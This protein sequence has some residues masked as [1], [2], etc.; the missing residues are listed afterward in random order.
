MF[1]LSGTI[2]IY[3][4]FIESIMSD[5]E[6]DSNLEIGSLVDTA[7][8]FERTID[9]QIQLIDGIDNK[10]EH[11]TRLLGILIGAI[12]SVLAV[13]VRI[14]NGKIEPPNTPLFI[15]FVFGVLSLILAMAFS[16]ITYLSSRFKIGLHYRPANLLSQG[17]YDVVD[18]KHYKRIIGTYGYALEKNKDVIEVNS[19][20]FRRALVFLLIGVI[21]LSGSGIS[22]ISDLT[23]KAAG[24]SL[25]VTSLLSLIIGGYI[26]SGR[27]LTLDDET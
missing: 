23:A 8:R 7:D 22:Y 21:F 6:E 13:G 15:M 4:A 17:D 11:V 26:F 3:Y 27:Y 16:I 10:A 9:H 19:K 18:R 1:V 24:W 5:D 12:L 14:N 20:R 2:P 25:I